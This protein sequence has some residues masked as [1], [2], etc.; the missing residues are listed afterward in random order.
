MHPIRKCSLD[1][2]SEDGLLNWLHVW[3]FK[4]QFEMLKL[5]FTEGTA[6]R[7]GPKKWHLYIGEKVNI[8]ISTVL[9][10]MR[11]LKGDLLVSSTMKIGTKQP[12]WRISPVASQLNQIFNLYKVKAVKTI[13]QTVKIRH[14]WTM[15]FMIYENTFWYKIFNPNAESW[16]ANTTEGYKYYEAINR[17]ERER[18]VIQVEE[19]LMPMLYKNGPT[20][21]RPN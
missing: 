11:F 19:A 14:D 10:A 18:H 2:D 20:L 21:N 16:P 4:H 12:N 3:S 8:S 13:Q 7:L 6:L 9:N 5:E 17:N 1:L 15:G